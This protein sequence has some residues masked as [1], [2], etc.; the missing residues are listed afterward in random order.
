MQKDGT[1]LLDD[2]EEEQLTDVGGKPR[3]LSVSSRKLRKRK[4]SSTA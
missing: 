2:V 4:Q 1:F 3:K